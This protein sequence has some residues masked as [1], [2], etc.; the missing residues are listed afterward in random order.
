MTAPDHTAVIIRGNPKF[1]TGNLAAEKFYA[2]LQKHMEQQGY[3][4]TQDAGE[5]H[6]VPAAAN[7]WLGHSRGVD[8]CRLAQ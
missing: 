8:R 1:I 2:K 3:A 5:P 6:T 7:V 4:V